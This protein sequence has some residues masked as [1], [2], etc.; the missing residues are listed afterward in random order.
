[1]ELMLSKTE[2]DLKTADDFN[3]DYETYLL[4]GGRFPYEDFKYITDILTEDFSISISIEKCPCT[5]QITGICDLCNLELSPKEIKIYGELRRKM[6][7]D[8]PA[9]NCPT[10]VNPWQ[11]HDVELAREI[12]LLTDPTRKKYEVITE[13]FPHMFKV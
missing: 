8:I 10:V 1:M 12:F 11:M 2:L 5:N 9:L 7:P 6:N 3:Q 13:L 4:G